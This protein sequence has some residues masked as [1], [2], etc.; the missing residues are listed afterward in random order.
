M[1]GGVLTNQRGKKRTIGAESGQSNEGGKS[2][3]ETVVPIRKTLV[4]G[5]SK[6]RVG[7]EK[8]FPRGRKR[9]AGRKGRQVGHIKKEGSGDKE[10]FLTAEPWGREPFKKWVTFRQKHKK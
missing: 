3:P 2:R 10:K 5:D 6:G 8:T 9:L 1:E 7:K 4:K